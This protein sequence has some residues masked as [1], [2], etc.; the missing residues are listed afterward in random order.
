MGLMLLPV[1]LGLVLAVPAL[2]PELVQSPNG[3]PVVLA[4]A[5]L[6][7]TPEQQARLGEIQT[8]AQ[9]QAS[10]IL[11]PAQQSQ[12]TPESLWQNT[13]HLNLT[14]TQK[15]QMTAIRMQVL[16]QMHSVLTPAQRQQWQAQR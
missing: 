1:L 2:S 9:D 8:Q 6:D 15:A 10:Q 13:Q 4:Q 5:Q 11:T 16:G 3:E 12:W 7:L 14:Q